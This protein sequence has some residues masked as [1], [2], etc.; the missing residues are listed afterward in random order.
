MDL[1]SSTTSPSIS[2]RLVTPAPSTDT[3][4]VT[5]AINGLRGAQ[6]RMRF[7]VGSDLNRLFNVSPQL[8]ELL[9]AHKAHTEKRAVGTLPYQRVA[10]VTRVELVLMIPVKWGVRRIGERDMVLP[11]RRRWFPRVTQEDIPR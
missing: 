10:M 8:Q 5:R 3:S 2:R 4:Q 9:R 7:Q 11:H 1:M 6:S